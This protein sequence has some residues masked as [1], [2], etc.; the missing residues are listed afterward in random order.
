MYIFDIIQKFTTT[1]RDPE[2]DE[3]VYDSEKII[4]NYT[5]NGFFRDFI[6]LIP[7]QLLQ[8]PYN[9]ENMFYLIKIIRITK[10]IEAFDIKN[11]INKFKDYNKHLTEM[12]VK[13]SRK[14]KCVHYSHQDKFLNTIYDKRFKMELLQEDIKIN[15]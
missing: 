8:L 10:A 13:A 5:K 11:L 4:S 6:A 12:K 3:K 7:L 9:F 2:S 14:K 15:F 1:Y